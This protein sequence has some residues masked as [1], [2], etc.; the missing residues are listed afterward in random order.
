MAKHFTVKKFDGDD[1]HSY[2]VFAKVDVKGMRSPIF[3]GQA[4][5]YVAGL[6]RASALH[7]AER[8]EK[9]RGA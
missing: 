3:Y 7:E 6:S 8:L 9:Q 1:C 4:T 5:P 2:A